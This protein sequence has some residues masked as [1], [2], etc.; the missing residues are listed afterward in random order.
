MHDPTTPIRYNRILFWGS[1][2]WVHTPDGCGHCVDG[3]SLT[4]IIE[5]MVAHCASEIII[6]DNHPA[7]LFTNTLDPLLS[8]RV[9]V[10]PLDPVLVKLRA[11]LKP[12]IEEFSINFD[13][14]A[15]R[16]E[17]KDE[18]VNIA[19]GI[20]CFELIQYLLGLQYRTQVDVRMGELQTAVRTVRGHSRSPKSRS[21]MAALEGVLNTYTPLECGVLTP[22]SGT[23]AEHIR[24]FK[25]LIEDAVYRSASET[26][27]RLG[28]PQ[29]ARRSAVQ[30]R[31]FLERIVTNRR[32]KQLFTLGTKSVTAATELPMPDSEAVVNILSSGFL[33]PIVSLRSAFKEAINAWENSESK[34]IY[35]SRMF[36][37]DWKQK[38]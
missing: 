9:N 6:P 37:R 15:F 19:L 34:P 23:P 8:R 24:I 32:F 29:R 5:E 7:S 38:E 27:H 3:S 22:S 36:R 33:P 16:S 4:Y 14:V 17:V 20:V 12:L 28:L 18:E 13:G 30:L 10:V 2:G 26:A 21:V 31:R 35:P 25:E 11:L 1:L